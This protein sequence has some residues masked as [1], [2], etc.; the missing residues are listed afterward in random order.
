MSRLDKVKN[1]FS[2]NPVTQATNTAIDVANTVIQQ[3]AAQQA[4]QTVEDATRVIPNME[5]F[6][7]PEVTPLVFSEQPQQAPLEL[8]AD[9]PTEPLQLSSPEVQAMDEEL[10]QIKIAWQWANEAIDAA[11][12]IVMENKIAELWWRNILSPI[13]NFIAWW[14]AWTLAWWLFWWIPW[15][16]I[17]WLVWWVKELINPVLVDKVDD[18]IWDNTIKKAVIQ[19]DETLWEMFN[20]IKLSAQKNIAWAKLQDWWNKLDVTEYNW[21][22]EKTA[23]R[24]AQVDYVLWENTKAIQ[25][26]RDEWIRTWD[27]TKYTQAS[28]NIKDIYRELGK[29]LW[30]EWYT[31]E[32]YN[33]E[34]SVVEWYINNVVNTKQSD[35]WTK[36][37]LK[38][39]MPDRITRERNTLDKFTKSPEELWNKNYEYRR[40]VSLANQQIIQEWNETLDRLQ[41]MYLSE[42]NPK[43]KENINSIIKDTRNFYENDVAWN[44]ELEAR[45]KALWKDAEWVR[46]EQKKVFWETFWEKKARL[47]EKIADWFYMTED[48]KN[49]AA[50][51]NMSIKDVTTMLMDSQ[52]IMNFW[53]NANLE[54]WYWNTIGRVFNLAN[55]TVSL[56]SEWLLWNIWRWAADIATL[57]TVDDIAKAWLKWFTSKSIANTIYRNADVIAQTAWERM[58]WAALL[59][60]IR[61][62][63]AWWKLAAWLEFG[64]KWAKAITTGVRWLE[65]AVKEWVVKNALI[66][67][68]FQSML[69]QPYT[70]T[71]AFFDTFLWWPLDLLDVWRAWKNELSNYKNIKDIFNG[72]LTKRDNLIEWLRKAWLWVDATTL[73]NAQWIIKEWENALL[74]MLSKWEIDNEA[75]KKYLWNAILRNELKNIVFWTW[76]WNTVLK[77][78]DDIRS[79]LERSQYAL[80]KLEYTINKWDWNTLVD[81]YFPHTNKAELDWLKTFDVKDLARNPD[82]VILEWFWWK[83][84]SLSE[85]SD[86]SFTVT[87]WVQ[88]WWLR[89]KKPTRT[90]I[91][92][93]IKRIDKIANLDTQI[94][95]IISEDEFRQWVKTTNW[96]YMSAKELKESLDKWDIRPVA[97][98]DWTPAW[99]QLNY[100]NE[101][102]YINSIKDR[103]GTTDKEFTDLLM[104]ELP[105]IWQKE[106]ENIQQTFNNLAEIRCLAKAEKN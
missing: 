13:W 58:S 52:T 72:D 14:A 49:I 93:D 61:F 19:A 32:R 71:D 103:V 28:S 95:W 36:I 80:Q 77:S 74:W 23:E 100:D 94:K 62:A 91:R 92:D 31:K 104:S 54:S 84:Q 66:G 4:L 86:T 42:K 106:V 41:F 47:F 24:V 59:R 10:N 2:P 12:N 105:W 56:V 82:E 65:A 30:I 69:W 38:D 73:V 83:K 57:W 15:A 102:V 29:E 1:F 101:A 39:Y 98:Q 78:A 11:N 8:S 9:V 44:L 55:S 3:Q 27:M 34:K 81:N 68:W 35:L 63:N 37:D 5:V 87:E 50:N 88:K 96:Q 17:W 16:I 21:T 75:F 43:L 67:W 26:L 79:T 45:A 22:L 97:W 51:N 40:Y 6:D 90:L 20:W 53:W 76:E 70:E 48:W 85:L 33:K 18:T 46:E 64:G 60:W 25:Q 7:A 99:Y 89:W